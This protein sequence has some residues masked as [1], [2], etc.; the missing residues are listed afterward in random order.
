MSR[1][2]FTTE[3]II[4]KLWEAEVASAT[5]RLTAAPRMVSRFASQNSVIDLPATYSMTK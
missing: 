2:R 1:K 4:H 5:V 3:Q